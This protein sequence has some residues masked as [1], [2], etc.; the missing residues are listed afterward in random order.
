LGIGAFY[1][2]GRG[3]AAVSGRVAGPVLGLVVTVALVLGYWYVRAPESTQVKVG[4]PAPELELYSIGAQRPTRLSTFRGS[5]VLLIM[6][7]S[8]C[9]VCE[10]EIWDVERLHR[11]YLQKGL[12]VIGVSVDPDDATRKAFLERHQITFI[13]LADDNG[14]AVRAAYGSWKMPEAYLIDGEGRV[15]AV[16][17]GSADWLG[18]VR[19]RVETLLPQPPQKRS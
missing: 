6:F 2:E 1:A 5:P 7:M 10:A 18:D 3:E 16:Y 19:E 15:D 4:Q 17:L 13:V 14:Q 9:R 12:R 11:R 8:G